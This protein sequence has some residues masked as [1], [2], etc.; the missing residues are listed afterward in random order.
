MRSI[1]KYLVYFKIQHSLNTAFSELFFYPLVINAQQLVYRIF[2][3]AGAQLRYT[4]L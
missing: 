3:A 1:L 4:Q 2:L